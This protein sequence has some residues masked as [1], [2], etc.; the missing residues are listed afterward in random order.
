MMYLLFFLLLFLSILL[1]YLLTRNFWREKYETEQKKFEE[2]KKKLSEENEKEKQKLIEELR[3]EVEKEKKKILE[4]QE[5]KLKELNEKDKELESLINL[6]QKKEKDYLL[7]LNRIQKK[8]NEL[9]ITEKIYKVKIEYLDKLINEYQ[10]RLLKIPNLSIS[11]I[12]EELKKTFEKEIWEEH[13][14]EL[15]K[16]KEKTNEETKIIAQKILLETCQKIA[17]PV[18]KEHSISFVEIPHDDFKRKLIGRKGRNIHLL[19]NLTGTEIIVDDTP[20]K[21]FIFSFNP[22]RRITAK[23]LIEKIIN[24]NEISAETIEKS[25]Q[26]TLEE[27]ERKIL[28]TGLETCKE[29]GIAN[30]SEELLKKIGEMEFYV[31]YG[32]NL[33][34]HSKEVAIISKNL[35][36]N[37]DIDPTNVLKAGLLHDIGKILSG[38]ENLPH[39]ISGANF[40]KKFGENEAV[41]QAIINHHQLDNFSSLESFLVSLAN[42]LSH[43]YGAGRTI[44]FTETF[45]RLIKIEELC[46]EIQEVKRAYAF[47]LGREIR[48]L[49]NVDKLSEK[50]SNLL[51]RNLQQKIRHET[52]MLGEIKINLIYEL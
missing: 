22:K 47:Q 24:E 32:Q 49:L 7:S 11:E 3:K 20:K 44:D 2:Y 40:V 34:A 30:F 51:I 17:L 39:Q 21:I 33:L 52:N 9:L 31:T 42:G 48:I 50:E 10:N 8:E 43:I 25:F 46:Q 27:L 45:K 5:K 6:Y 12:K 41:I 19:E 13:F 29:L 16:I 14:E 4:E 36:L 15:K 35:A 23:L 18:A 37:F 28:Q 1:T 38:E 26:K